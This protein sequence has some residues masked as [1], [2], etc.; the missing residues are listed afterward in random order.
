MSWAGL[1]GAAFYT[2]SD[3]AGRFQFSVDSADSCDLMVDDPRYVSN[4]PPLLRHNID[5]ALLTAYERDWLITEANR[6]DESA[7][8]D[9]CVPLT[10]AGARRFVGLLRSALVVGLGV[11][12][13]APTTPL[14]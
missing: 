14:D 5:N 1:W 10:G 6:A 11:P 7:L 4:S 12:G 13:T 8:R 3:E 9:L 2:A